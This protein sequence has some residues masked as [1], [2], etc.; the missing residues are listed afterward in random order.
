M[1]TD[2]FSPEQRSA[3]MRAVKGAGT[4]PERRLLAALAALGLAP[5]VQ[6][7]DLPGSPDFVFRPQS[8]AVFVH[9]C[10]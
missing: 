1:R 4:G 3:V 7:R 10:F 2:V 9:G 5:Q 8:V 6:A